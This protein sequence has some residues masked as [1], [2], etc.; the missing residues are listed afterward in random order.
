MQINTARREVSSSADLQQNDFSISMGPGMFKILTSSIYSDVQRIAMQE[1]ICNAIDANTAADRPLEP[2]KV[3]LPNRLEPFFSVEDAGLG[4]SHDFVMTNYNRY[5]HST[6]AEDNQSIGGFGLGSKAPLAYTDTFEVH[7]RQAGEERKYVAY[8]GQDGTPSIALVFTGPWAGASGT[9]VKFPVK[10]ADVQ[11][12]REKAARNFAFLTPQPAWPQGFTIEQ[13]KYVLKGSNWAFRER[14]Y[15]MPDRAAHIIMGGIAYPVNAE[16]LDSSVKRLAAFPIHIT[17]PVGTVEPSVSRSELNYNKETVEKLTQIFKQVQAEI[18]QNIEAEITKCPTLW[19]AIEAYNKFYT[20]MGY[21]WFSGQNVK[22]KGLNCIEGIIVELNKFPGVDFAT[23][24]KSYSGSGIGK[25]APWKSS[26]SMCPT[27]TY[28]PREGERTIFVYD[29][30]THKNPTRALHEL[31][32]KQ[33]FR[34]VFIMRGGSLDDRARFIEALGNPPEVIDLGSLPAIVRAKPQKVLT[35]TLTCTVYKN[36]TKL[37]NQIVNLSEGGVYFIESRGT[38][39]G[40]Y[41]YGIFLTQAAS[42]SYYFPGPVYIFPASARRKLAKAAGWVTGETF[43]QERH[44]KATIEEG[45]D[46]AKATVAQNTCTWIAETLHLEGLYTEWLKDRLSISREFNQLMKLVEQNR[47]DFETLEHRRVAEMLG[48]A[49]DVEY[50]R[51]GKIEEIWQK[52]L[53]KLP[54][55]PY[56]SHNTPSERIFN[57][58]TSTLRRRT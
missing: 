49:T 48:Q 30:R 31:L 5:G 56:I 33:S 34:Q 7:T 19:Q 12:F 38:I 58:V 1:P 2:V 50:V 44:E 10:G 47:P 22:W 15:P 42:N 23:Y 25:I 8:I 37:R 4:M 16:S 20:S 17:V 14:Y 29:D 43:L 51:A 53:D 45:F 54:L 35:T 28:S 46:Y 52:L 11:S 55:L 9:L 26:Y 41:S 13:P 24:S 18:I 36:G 40:W 6:K 39:T 27:Y 57:Y 21:A 3:H 32:G